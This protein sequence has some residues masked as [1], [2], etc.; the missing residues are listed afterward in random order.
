M[1]TKANSVM[2]DLVTILW[3]LT[4]LIL[5]SDAWWQIPIGLGLGAIAGYFDQKRAYRHQKKCEDLIWTMHHSKSKIK[6]WEAFE[7]LHR[8]WCAGLDRLALPDE[9]IEFYKLA[10]WTWYGKLKNKPSL[11]LKERLDKQAK[12][13]AKAKANSAKT[14]SS[15][16]SSQRRSARRVS[17]PKRQPKRPSQNAKPS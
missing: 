6:R 7:E 12:D 13:K 14:H 4:L 17:S 2:K 3:I 11:I 1:Q 15:R 10:E 5:F 9:D 16:P 8:I